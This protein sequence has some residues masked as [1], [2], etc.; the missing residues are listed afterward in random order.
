MK[1]RFT[2]CELVMIGVAVLIFSALALPVLANNSQRGKALSCAGNLAS[3]GK[4]TALYINDYGAFPR[5]G[6]KTERQ[7]GCNPA[8]SYVTLTV[9]Y[10]GVKL[11]K[12]NMIPKDTYIPELVCPDDV[13]P[14]VPD[15]VLY[16]Q[17][18]CSYTTNNMLTAGGKV[19]GGI[20]YGMSLDRVKRPAE[21]YHIFDAAGIRDFITAIGPF[22]HARVGYRHRFAGSGNGVVP[23]YQEQLDGGVNVL[24]ADGHT[25]NQ[26][27]RSLTCRD[28]N[29]PM[30]K[31]WSA[32]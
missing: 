32:R 27:G 21:T 26:S 7:F 5:R 22:T 4:A 31:Y 9:P 13:S 14:A 8:M 19:A 16:G 18:G 28:T 12:P 11:E 25:G 29:D 23:T 6:I 24:Y 10:L 15:D 3:L 20:A 2:F 17:G 30:Y 1:K